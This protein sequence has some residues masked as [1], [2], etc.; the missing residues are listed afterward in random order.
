MN[1]DSDY[2]FLKDFSERW[3]RAWNSH[4]TDALLELLH[5]DIKWDDKTFWP[6]A[7]HGEAEVRPYI[8][9]IWTVMHDVQFDD[10]QTFFARDCLRAV[11]LFR[12][13]G[14]PPRQMPGWKPFDMHG[15]DIFM[16]FKDGLLSHY[17]SSYDIVNMMCQMGA[18]P[19]RGDKAGG[20]YLLSLL[21][22]SDSQHASGGAEGHQRG[23]CTPV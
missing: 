17:L 20:A 19:E 22:A 16:A 8:D 15:C 1:T 23:A 7:M 11:V 5:P 9:K 4:S 10:M 3:L 18:L 12:Q 2:A 21:R 6:K 14:S 13:R